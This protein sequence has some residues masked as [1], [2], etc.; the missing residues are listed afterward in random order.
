MAHISKQKIFNRWQWQV[1]L[2]FNFE[3]WFF[4]RPSER[5][6]SWQSLTHCTGSSRKDWN[7][8]WLISHNFNRTFR[9]AMC[10][11]EICATVLDWRS[12]NSMSFNLWKFPATSEWQGK[13]MSFDISID[14]SQSAWTTDN[15]LTILEGLNCSRDA[16]KPLVTVK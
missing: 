9:D 16:L 8:Q 12:D 5:H 4:D 10:L 6:Y 3:K 15:Y 13:F 14:Y 11:R 1:K 2:T 7:I